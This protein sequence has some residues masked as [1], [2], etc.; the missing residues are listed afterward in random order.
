[1]V[2]SS[3]RKGG[4]LVVAG[5]TRWSEEP[6]TWWNSPAFSI[7]PDSRGPYAEKDL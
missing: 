7:M 6:L 2:P 3:W 1:V 5:D 4:P